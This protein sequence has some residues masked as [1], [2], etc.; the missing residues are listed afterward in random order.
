MKIKG[1]VSR[2]NMINNYYLPGPATSKTLKFMHA[3]Y[4]GQSSTGTGEWYLS[5]NIME[6]SKSLTNDNY[7]GLDLTEIPEADR[8]SARAAKAFTVTALLPHQNAKDALRDVLE[9]AGATLPKRDAVD[10]RIINE[11][12][13]RTATGMGSFGKPGIIDSPKAVGGWPVYNTADAPADSDHDGMPDEWE[14]QNGLD[15]ND[16]ADRNKT[17]KDGYTMLETYLNSLVK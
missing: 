3:L 12:K 2:V 1:G 10:A 15:N 5:G 13:T 17:G 16:P 11:V 6:G 8:A 9:N 4:A 7:K 14:K